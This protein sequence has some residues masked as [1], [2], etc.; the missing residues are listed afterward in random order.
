MLLTTLIMLG[1]LFTIL[2]VPVE[3]REESLFDQVQVLDRNVLNSKTVS[4]SRGD[5]ERIISQA[6][7]HKERVATVVA[8]ISEYCNGQIEWKGRFWTAAC[9][10]DVVLEENELV[11]VVAIKELTCIVE[12]LPRSLCPSHHLN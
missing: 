8:P 10:E 3:R 2:Q 6:M 12:K 7:D 5:K 9:Y 1:F 4:Q 11:Y